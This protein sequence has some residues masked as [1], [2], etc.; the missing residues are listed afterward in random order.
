MAVPV[1]RSINLAPQ[2]P[3]TPAVQTP[4]V[5]VA[6]ARTVPRREP[7]VYARLKPPT[8]PR[9]DDRQA[10]ILR[11]IVA[12]SLDSFF[13][14]CAQSTECGIWESE[15]MTSLLN[16]ALLRHPPLMDLVKNVLRANGD[17]GKDFFELWQS[18]GS[19]T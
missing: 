3:T 4:Q 10:A 13:K 7:T 19:N 1:N 8:R 9:A 14:S 5:G 15:A 2:G 16:E 18:S 6:A 11:D 12:D 17:R